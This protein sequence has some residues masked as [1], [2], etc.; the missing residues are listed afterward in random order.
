MHIVGA[1]DS[2][3]MEKMPS[4]LERDKDKWSSSYKK[5]CMARLMKTGS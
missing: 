2:I 4:P 1:C 5:L 3:H